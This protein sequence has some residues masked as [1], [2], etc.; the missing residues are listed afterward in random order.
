MGGCSY[1]VSRGFT[2]VYRQRAHRLDRG[3]WIGDDRTH[4]DVDAVSCLL[5]LVCIHFVRVLLL[6]EKYGESRWWC[7]SKERLSAAPLGEREA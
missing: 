6:S 2:G 1:L 4:L 7:E 5:T 3:R